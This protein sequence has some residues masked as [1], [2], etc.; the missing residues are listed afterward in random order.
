MWRCLRWFELVKLN[1]QGI[2][3]VW[4]LTVEGQ[5]AFFC[6]T[7]QNIVVKLITLEVYNYEIKTFHLSPGDVFGF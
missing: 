6:I 7:T 3:T 4:N 1:E 5:S 2:I